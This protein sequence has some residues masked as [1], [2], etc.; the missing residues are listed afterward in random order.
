MNY[1]TKIV[2][3]KFQKINWNNNVLSNIE[4]IKILYCIETTHRNI[5]WRLAEYLC[6]IIMPRNF[7]YNRKITIGKFQIKPEYVKNKSK[8]RTIIDSNKIET[9]DNLLYKNFPDADWKSLPD[10]LLKDIVAFYNGDKTG[11]YLETAKLLI[12]SNKN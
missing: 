4:L 3:K 5:I 9:I 7:F 2:L 10:K 11:V 1:Y 12:K 6:W 8:I